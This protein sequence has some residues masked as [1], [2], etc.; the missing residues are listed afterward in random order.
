M[1]ALSELREFIRE[2]DNLILMEGEFREEEE[3]GNWDYINR[4][5]LEGGED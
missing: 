4:E 2:D 5:A 3:G 1:P